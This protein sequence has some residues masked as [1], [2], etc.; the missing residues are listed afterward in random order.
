MIYALDPPGRPGV[1]ARNRLGQSRLWR[2]RG[3]RRPPIV[4]VRITSST[5][6]S[7]SNRRLRCHAYWR[8]KGLI[9][10]SRDPERGLLGLPGRPPRPHRGRPRRDGLRGVVDKPGGCSSARRADLR[11]KIA[12]SSRPSARV[13]LEDTAG[14][15]VE[16]AERRVAPDRMPAR[17]TR[18]PPLPSPVASLPKRE[19]VFFNGLGGFTADGRE[20]V[21]SSSRAH[22]RPL[23]GR[24]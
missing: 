20:Y 11:R 14:T 5:A 17:L 3:L 24:T 12:S 2:F 6:S 16:Q 10:G 19:R 8:M 18:N 22:R 4:L 1:I 21:I 13:I 9:R 23:R 15:L 7:W